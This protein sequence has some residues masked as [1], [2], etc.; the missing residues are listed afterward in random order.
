MEYTFEI[1]FDFVN[2]AKLGFVEEKVSWG[3]EELSQ[4]PI[5]FLSDNGLRFE[6]SK[7]LITWCL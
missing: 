1:Y 6:E 5:V 7:R 2:T 4:D 3:G